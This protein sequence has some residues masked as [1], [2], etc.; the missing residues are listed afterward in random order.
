VVLGW[1][2]LENQLVVQLSRPPNRQKVPPET[3][4]ISFEDSS[5]IAIL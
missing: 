3:L 4:S 5:R 2:R 1:Q